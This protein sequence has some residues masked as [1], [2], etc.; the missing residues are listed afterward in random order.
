M[1]KFV[2]KFRKNGSYDED[3]SFEK[4]RHRN[5]HSEAKKM[6]QRKLEEDLLQSELQ[7]NQPTAE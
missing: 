3:F 7:T 5:E 1:S 4:K 2:G 6:L